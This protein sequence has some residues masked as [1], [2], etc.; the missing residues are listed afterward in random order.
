MKNLTQP[1]IIFFMV[2]QLSAKW[3]EVNLEICDTPNL[4]RLAK[5]GTTYCNAFTNNPVCCAARATIATGLTTRGHGVLQNGYELSP[6]IPTFMNILKNNGWQTSAFGKVHLKSHF[7][8]SYPNYKPYGFDTFKITE[9]T[10]AGEWLDWIE[11]E[12][13]NY[14]DQALATIWSVEIPEFQAY[15]KNKINL[16]QKCSEVRKDFNWETKEF[17]QNTHSMYTLPF[18]AELSQTEWITN[19]AIEYIENSDIKMPLYMHISYVQPH[20]PHCPPA[21]YMN[22][23]STKNIP[24]PIK[25]EW[26]ND[27][28]HPTCFEGSEGALT[29]I[30]DD[31]LNTRHYY[32]ADIAHLDNNIGLVLDS[33]K[34]NNRMDNT[35]IVFLSDHG[36]MLLDHGFTGKGERHYDTSIRIPLMICGEGFKSNQICED[37]VTLE[38]IFPTI[39]DIT[40]LSLPQLQLF[41]EAQDSVSFEGNK[42]IKSKEFPNYF[43]PGKSLLP[44]SSLPNL[45]RNFVYV[46][47]YNNI[48]SF[49]PKNWARTIRT[50]SWRY[51]LYPMGGGE[52]LFDLVNDSN[53][54]INLSKHPQYAEIRQMLKDQ[55]MEAIILQ[56][57]PHSPNNLYMLGVH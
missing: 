15:G 47:S 19:N 29:E 28:N 7:H 49:T 56:D 2:D 57:Y 24:T 55:L 22:K 25:P 6:D 45:E 52:Q 10:R 36:D 9:D 46:E 50:L 51:T 17:P 11:K 38:D 8:T 3:L 12:H 5:T 30:P 43:Y 26:I 31:W 39:L 33:L 40:N 4:N 48:D 27:R 23:V 32:Y 54:L 37:F 21:E 20:S 14:Y 16:S 34:E 35:Y 18:P 13:P 44:N 41:K 42:N 1:N 53:E